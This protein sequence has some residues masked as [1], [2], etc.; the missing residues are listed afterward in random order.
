MCEY[1]LF[2]FLF[3]LIFFIALL[4]GLGANQKNNQ[5]LSRLASRF[6]GAIP[7]FSWLPSFEGNYQGF[8]FNILLIP[9]GR[10]SPARLTAK[11]FK[12]SSL[13]LRIYR[14]SFLSRL[15]KSLGL[16]REVKTNDPGF[17]QDFLIFANLE[18]QAISYFYNQDRKNTI[19][20]LFGN[21]FDTFSADGKVITVTKPNYSIERD[22]EPGAIQGILDKLIFLSQ[23]LY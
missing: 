15:G 22:I 14:E 2:P 17:D 13:K 12:N 5:V 6:N 10:H 20:E 16:V 19:R 3:F 4:Y 21:G 18:T 23:G 9:A 8:K 7:G 11:L 1:S